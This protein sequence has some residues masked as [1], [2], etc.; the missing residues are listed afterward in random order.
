MKRIATCLKDI[1]VWAACWLKEHGINPAA[2]FAL[3]TGAAM[4]I[5]LPKGEPCTC[6]EQLDPEFV[7][8]LQQQR[9]EDYEAFLKSRGTTALCAVQWLQ[10]KDKLEKRQ[11]LIQT[12]ANPM[13]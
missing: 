10:L 1:V 5:F 13:Q 12:H 8:A 6:E 11:P 4:A 2:P 7:E 3:L 9:E